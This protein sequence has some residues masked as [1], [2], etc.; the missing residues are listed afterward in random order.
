MQV[1]INDKAVECEFG[2]TLTSVLR[3]SGIA[4][5]HVAVAVDFEVVP[6]GEWESTRLEEGSSIII[7]KASQG[8]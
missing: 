7:I 2:A 5:D 1:F 4:T 6:A 8:G 3:A